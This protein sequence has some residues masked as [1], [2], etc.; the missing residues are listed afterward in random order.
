MKKNKKTLSNKDINQSTDSNFV[1]ENSDELNPRL[2]IYNGYRPGDYN[3]QLP[4]ITNDVFMGESPTQNHFVSAENYIDWL[5]INGIELI[6]HLNHLTSCPN[7]QRIISDFSN[8]NLLYLAQQSRERL[9]YILSGVSYFRILFTN[10]ERGEYASPE[11]RSNLFRFINQ[12]L[13]LECYDLIVTLN[14]VIRLQSVHISQFGPLTNRDADTYNFILRLQTSGIIS[15]LYAIMEHLTR[16]TIRWLFPGANRPALTE[17]IL[18]FSDEHPFSDFN[19][20]KDPD[21]DSDESSGGVSSLKESPSGNQAGTSQTGRSSANTSTNQSGGNQTNTTKSSRNISETK[22]TKK[23]NHNRLFLSMNWWM[24]MFSSVQKNFNLE[25]VNNVDTSSRVC[26]RKNIVSRPMIVQRETIFEKQSFLT[27]EMLPS[28][29]TDFPLQDT[30]DRILESKQ[31]FSLE[32]HSRLSLNLDD[33]QDSKMTFES[34]LADVQAPVFSKTPKLFLKKTFQVAGA[35]SISSETFGQF[36]QQLKGF[37]VFFER[38]AFIVGIVSI[39]PTILGC[40]LWGLIFA[41][42]KKLGKTSTTVSILLSVMVVTDLS[43]FQGMLVGVFFA[44]TFRGFQLQEEVYENTNQLSLYK[45]TGKALSLT[46]FLFSLAKAIKACSMNFSWKIVVEQVPSIILVMLSTQFGI[47]CIQ[48]F[49]GNKI[50]FEGFKIQNPN[51]LI[52]S[53][54][55]TLT[56]VLWGGQNVAFYLKVASSVVIG[57]AITVQNTNFFRFNEKVCVEK[58]TKILKES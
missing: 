47:F 35:A 24:I 40:V 22:K 55:A 46:V 6:I 41:N 19:K 15:Q 28:E 5:N 54:A 30:P 26:F 11:I 23:I 10:M 48:K 3:L 37:V 58:D 45:K 16:N 51:L 13:L 52:N 1:F 14:A 44:K 17:F 25:T 29:I 4:E 42:N 18:E 34:L 56:V 27:E 20:K 57:V 9:G 31:N 7:R 39:L 50:F 8:L 2:R 32:N 33:F 36:D 53:I 12:L 49:F 38:N 43:S 21:P